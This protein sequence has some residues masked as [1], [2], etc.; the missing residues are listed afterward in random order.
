MDF[1][2]WNMSQPELVPS[3]TPSNDI[4]FNDITRIFSTSYSKLFA[5]GYRLMRS[6]EE[7]Q[8]L[9]SYAFL[10]A[11]EQDMKHNLKEVTPAWFYRVIHNKAISTLRKKSH[12]N[13][14]L[15]EYESEEYAVPRPFEDD[16]ITRVELD[17]ALYLM[18]LSPHKQNMQSL[19]VSSQTSTDR[20][21]AKMLGV[22]HGALKSRNRRA[23]EE[24]K[25]GVVFSEADA[26]TFRERI[27]QKAQIILTTSEYEIYACRLQGLGIVEMSK[28]LKLAIPTITH[29]IKAIHS[30]FDLVRRKTLQHEGYSDI[31]IQNTLLVPIEWDNVL[32]M[33]DSVVSPRTRRIMNNSLRN[34]VIPEE[35][36]ALLYRQNGFD[37]HQIAQA[38][39][40][41]W[42]SAAYR[43]RAGKQRVQ[44][45]T[46]FQLLTEGR[47]GPRVIAL[48]MRLPLNKAKEYIKK[49]QIEMLSNNDFY[50]ENRHTSQTITHVL[51][52]TDTTMHRSRRD[53]LNTLSDEE[54]FTLFSQKKGD[55]L[56][57]IAHQ[58]S[59]SERNVSTISEIARGKLKTSRLLKLLEHGHTR[60]E[61]TNSLHFPLKET[62]FFDDQVKIYTRE[63]CLEMEEALKSVL[64]PLE[65]EVLMLKQQGVE[66]RAI[67]HNLQLEF[68]QVRSMYSSGRKKVRS[69]EAYLLG[70]RRVSTEVIAQ[71]LKVS[72]PEL[73]TLFQRGVSLAGN[74]RKAS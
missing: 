74:L 25:H 53:I 11:V 56:R 46:A 45:I 1:N 24:L 73:E 12:A 39:N 61:I 3:Y 50:N 28:S 20:E 13:E 6:E 71:H 35:F 4:Q 49:G 29:R 70:R 72:L 18:K 26:N 37:L 48:I 51:G 34:K 52:V 2:L 5:Y 44:A 14:P 32:E 63:H 23:R 16:V 7:A 21:A 10:Q 66:D 9:V 33:T 67:E 60:E 69:L 43:V 47:L 19:L 42:D 17:E 54:Y 55:T 38:T 36:T 8:D 30:K 64:E 27:E 65:Y 41:S 40:T 31:E 58:I 68:V 59:V 57:D 15:A 22:T 62:D